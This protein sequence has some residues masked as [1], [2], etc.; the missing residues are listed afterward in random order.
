MPSAE[1]PLAKPVRNWFSVLVPPLV[2]VLDSAPS[3]VPV[4]GPLGIDVQDSHYGPHLPP[5]TLTYPYF[6]RP[7]GSSLFTTSIMPSS[8]AFCELRVDGVLKKFAEIVIGEVRRIPLPRTRVN[9]G[10]KGRPGLPCLHPG[11]LVLAYA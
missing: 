1:Q 3:A 8:E 2:V 6:C 10:K 5:T 4:S 11:P 9:K 7:G